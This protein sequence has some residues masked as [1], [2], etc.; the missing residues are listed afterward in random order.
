MFENVI[1]GVDRHGGGR[2]AI[3]LAKQLRDEAGCL[4]LAHVYSDHGHAWG[5][6]P[7]EH[8]L[9]KR[10]KIA[11]LLETAGKEAGVVAAMRWRESPSVGRGLHELCESLEA[12][13]L[14]VGSS[15]RGL[16]G[17]VLLGDDTRAALNGAPCAVAITPAGYAQR[18]GTIGKIGVA[19]NGSPESEHALAVARTMA[20]ERGATLSALEAVT[21]PAYSLIGRAT[22][23]A[24]IEELVEDARER[25]VALGGIEPHAV[26]GAPA[27]ELSL[28]SGSLDLLVVGS[29]GYGPIGRLVHGTTSQP[30]VRMAR[31]PLLVLTRTAR[32]AGTTHTIEQDEELAAAAE[33]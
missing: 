29:R 31:C 26:Y 9:D 24:A 30:L 22:V 15:H 23:D 20:A 2:D 12:D 6:S 32:A 17:R 5:G 14:V 7:P 28:Y 1:V 16:L 21:L 4:T 3:A 11:E 10:A 8:D 25:I 19:Y 18:P 13:L 27:E 33:T